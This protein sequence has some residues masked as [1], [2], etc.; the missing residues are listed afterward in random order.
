MIW[1]FGCCRRILILLFQMETYNDQ[2]LL[3]QEDYSNI[4]VRFHDFLTQQIG[5][6][7]NCSNQELHD[8]PS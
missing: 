4:G 2:E 1:I 3:T 7:E 5:K 6:L 8:L